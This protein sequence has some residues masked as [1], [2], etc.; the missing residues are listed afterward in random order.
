MLKSD[1]YPDSKKGFSLLEL[2]CYHKAVQCFKLLRTKFNLSITRMCLNF[3]FLSGN[4]EIMNECLKFKTPDKKCMKYAIISHNIDF[5]T[6][7]MNEHNIKIDLAS[8][9]RFLN[10]NAFFIYVDQANEINRCFAFSGGFNSLSFCLYFSYKGV[11]VNAANEK[12]RTALHYAA[13]YNSLEIAQYLI[14]KGIDVN[15]R[16][17]KGYNS[18]S[19]AF[20][21][22]NFEMLDLLKSHGAIPT[23]EVGLRIGFMN[24]K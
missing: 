2:C 23:F 9:C 19:C 1:L 10:L 5:V 3:S 15:A 16:D 8:C 7:L 6:Y 4:P 20:Y 22:Q 17:I 18:L 13:K 12:G 24:K 11:D 21:Q 14:S